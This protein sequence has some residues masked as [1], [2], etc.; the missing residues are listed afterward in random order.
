V[1]AG[2]LEIEPVLVVVTA[3]SLGASEY[4]EL[5]EAFGSKVHNNYGATEAAELSFDC[6]HGW[7][8][9]NSDWF[10]FEPVM[11]TIGRYRRASAPIQFCS[12]TS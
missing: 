5:S 1:R 4:R 12:A 8:H 6:E 9:M 2:R 7:H 10:I 11:P 3:E